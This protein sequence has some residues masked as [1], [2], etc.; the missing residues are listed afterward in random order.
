[1]AVIEPGVLPIISLA[2]SPTALPS[3][4]TLPL[5]LLTPTTVGSLST[6][7]SPLMQTSVLH[8]HRSMPMSMLNMPSSE[9]KI[10]RSSP[11]GRELVCTLCLHRTRER[12]VSDRCATHAGTAHSTNGE[13][14]RMR[15]DGQTT[16][17][18]RSAAAGGAETNAA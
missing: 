18:S 14:D 11:P 8:V 15:T 9:S 10:T 3:C 2:T 5:R 7:P 17:R 6:I 1:M 13:P 12:Y 16:D 4:R